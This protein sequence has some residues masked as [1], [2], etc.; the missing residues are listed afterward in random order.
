MSPSLSFHPG[1]LP[2]AWT[3]IFS[4]VGPFHLQNKEVEYGGAAFPA[5]S[6]GPSLQVASEQGMK[7]D[8]TQSPSM[9]T[10]ALKL[11]VPFPHISSTLAPD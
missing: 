8:D 11:Q 9:G 2:R 6:S 4:T 3:L 7:M 1:E 5:F 10:L